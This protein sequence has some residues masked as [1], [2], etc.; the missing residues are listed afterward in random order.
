MVTAIATEEALVVGEENV[1]VGGSLHRTLN[2]LES[3]LAMALGRPRIVIQIDS[4][5]H[6]VKGTSLY[7]DTDQ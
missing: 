7:R 1:N 5:I 2:R 6:L 3:R 4:S